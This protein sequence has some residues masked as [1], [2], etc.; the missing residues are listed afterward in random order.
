[1]RPLIQASLPLCVVKSSTFILRVSDPE[2]EILDS[3]ASIP[4]GEEGHGRSIFLKKM[5]LAMG[6]GEGRWAPSLEEERK[7]EMESKV[8][9]LRTREE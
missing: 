9:R 5:R 2:R 1:M 6:R 4:S 8:V 3:V 7:T